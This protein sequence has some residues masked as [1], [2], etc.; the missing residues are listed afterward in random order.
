MRYVEHFASRTALFREVCQRDMEGIVAK[1]AWAPYN[2]DQPSWV[3][4]KDPAYS[5]ME[6][7]WDFFERAPKPAFR[8][9]H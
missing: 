3:K 8:L 6:K 7:R 5:Q 2:P 1:R 9:Q 4:I